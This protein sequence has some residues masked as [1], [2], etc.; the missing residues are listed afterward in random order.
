VRTSRR[1]G[2]VDASGPTALAACRSAGRRR[3][4][5]AQ[6]R[7]SSICRGSPRPAPGRLPPRPARIVSPS[8]STGTARLGTPAA[9]RTDPFH[10]SS[11]ACGSGDTLLLQA[12]D[13]GIER[14]DKTMGAHSG[15]GCGWVV[16]GRRMGAHSPCPDVPCVCSCCGPTPPAEPSASV[17]WGHRHQVSI[18]RLRSPGPPPGKEALSPCGSCLRLRL[19]SRPDPPPPRQASRL[20]DQN[21][22]K[23]CRDGWTAVR[24]GK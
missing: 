21:L 18:A 8:G 12:H 24:N 2:S 5:P 16:P 22:H 23:P 17:G 10:T 14:E 20:L 9:C 3:P 15:C 6:S 1:A 13:A 19:R 4:R 11:P 7:C